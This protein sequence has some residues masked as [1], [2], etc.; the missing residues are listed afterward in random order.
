MCLWT[1]VAAP[2]FAAAAMNPATVTSLSQPVTR[3][4][5]EKILKGETVV[6]LI[7]RHPIYHLDV[8]GAVSAPAHEVWEV[9]T[10]YD[11]YREFLPLVTESYLRKRAGNVAYQYIKMNPPWPFHDQ[12]MVNICVEDKKRWNLSWTMG[13]GN[14]KLEHGFW[15]LTPMP[16]GRTRMQYHLT[17]DPWMDAMP[18]WVVEWVTRNVM[19]DILKGV[20]K[21]VAANQRA[22]R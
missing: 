19:P 9:V 15:Q 20:R 17:V 10:T 14:V 5:E 2:A 18:G 4:M 7:N 16:D 11:A 3:E 22:K 8:Y 1:A 12:W 13:E 6:T 21:R